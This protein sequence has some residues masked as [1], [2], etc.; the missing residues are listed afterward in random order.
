MHDVCCQHVCCQ[1]IQWLCKPAG[2]YCLLGAIA[3]LDSHAVGYGRLADKRLVHIMSQ[4][5]A[6]PQAHLGHVERQAQHKSVAD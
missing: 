3:L 6:S 1:P 4:L 2:G 5:A